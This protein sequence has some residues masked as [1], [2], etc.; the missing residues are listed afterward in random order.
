MLQPC[1]LRLSLPGTFNDPELSWRVQDA[2]LR[3]LLM[4]RVVGAP[5]SVMNVLRNVAPQL[6]ALMRVSSTSLTGTETGLS[7]PSLIRTS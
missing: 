4:Q 3:G 6:A 1:T 7:A 5:T 2:V